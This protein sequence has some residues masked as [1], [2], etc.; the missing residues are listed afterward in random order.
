MRMRDAPTI[1]LLCAIVLFASPGMALA[2][3]TAACSEGGYFSRGLGYG[4]DIWSG[5]RHGARAVLQDQNLHLC[6]SPRVGE[7]SASTAW[8]AI[9]GNI[10]GYSP[11]NIVQVGIGKCRTASGC[12]TTMH[13]IWSVGWVEGTPGCS[14]W[15]TLVP[16]PHT[17]A[18][19]S[20]GHR[21]TV[22]QISSNKTYRLSS[23]QYVRDEDVCW[24]N[25]FVE[26]FNETWDKGDALGGYVGNHFWFTQMEFQET[27]GGSWRDLAGL[28]NDRWREDG[29]TLESIFKCRSEGTGA[30]STWTDR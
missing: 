24:T 4:S 12:S 23:Y 6:T 16:S 2:A 29:G 17:T 7:G 5:H 14:G 18:F 15:G 21:F 3:D 20:G 1:A 26:I 11:W 25:N 13:D 30:I 9:E 27:F 22:T 10:A 19:Y 8:V 28:C